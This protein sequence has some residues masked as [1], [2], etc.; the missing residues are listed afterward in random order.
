MEMV[1]IRDRL[2]WSRVQ[3]S[4]D[5]QVRSELGSSSVCFELLESKAVVEEAKPESN[6]Y[7]DVNL[8]K[9][10]PHDALVGQGFGSSKGMETMLCH[11]IALRTS[12]RSQRIKYG[13]C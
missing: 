5:Q 3:S 11:S 6:K 1:R 12:C 8:L 10:S 9:P 7:H 4:S 13:D 2:S